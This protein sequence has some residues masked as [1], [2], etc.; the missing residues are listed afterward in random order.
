MKKLIM[1]INWKLV[2]E[3]A[4]WFFIGYSAGMIVAYLMS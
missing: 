4:S 2:M 3:Y 1:S